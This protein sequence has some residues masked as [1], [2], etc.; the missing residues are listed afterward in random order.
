MTF[1]NSWPLFSKYDESEG[2]EIE[3]EEVTAQWTPVPHV[4]KDGNLLL[5]Y[6]ESD[7]GCEYRDRGRIRY[8]PGGSIKVIKLNLSRLGNLDEARVDKL[9]AWTEPAMVYSI[10]EENFVPKNIANPAVAL[11][12]AEDE[13]I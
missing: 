8:V 4:D 9:S 10:Y 5:F 13:N 11:E 1:G 7:G 2:G 3:D 12:N 6:A